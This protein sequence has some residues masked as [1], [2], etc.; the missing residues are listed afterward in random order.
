MGGISDA[1]LVTNGPTIAPLAV[2]EVIC[3]AL[4]KTIAP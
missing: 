4:L 1:H 2:K 3:V